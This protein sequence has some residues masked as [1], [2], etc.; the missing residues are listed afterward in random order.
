MPGARS[1]P[2]ILKISTNTQGGQSSGFLQ[3]S[4]SPTASFEVLSEMYSSKLNAYLSSMSKL[5]KYLSE[6]YSSKLNV[7]LD[8]ISKLFKYLSEIYSSQLDVYLSS[9]S[10]LLKYNFKRAR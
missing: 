9:I 5:L 7:Y 3:A 2:I 1:L 4:F 8:S 10:K 6:I